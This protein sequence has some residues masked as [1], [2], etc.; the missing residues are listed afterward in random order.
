MKQEYKILIID[1]DLKPLK[2]HIRLLQR[3][4]Y[5]IETAES[6]ED[7]LSAAVEFNPHL[8]LLDILLPDIKGFEVCKKLKSIPD[9]K[10]PFIVMLSAGMTGPDN[11][12]KGFESGADDYLTKPITKEVL[13]ARINAIFRMIKAEIALAEEKEKLKL[14]KEEAESANRAKSMFLANMS[15]EIR[16]PMN[17]I[18]GMLNILLDSNLSPDQIDFIKSATQSAESLLTIINDILDYS[19]VEAG[20]LTLNSDCF[21]LKESIDQI[22]KTLIFSARDKGLTFN[23]QISK[24]VPQYLRGDSGRLRQVLVNLI[25]NAIKFT[26][27]GKVNLEI[28]LEN[29]AEKCANINF[30]VIDTGIGISDDQKSKLFKSFSQ[31]DS[32]ITRKYGGTGLGLAI[33][34]KLIE[35]MGGK[36]GVDSKLNEG[37]IF[38]FSIC[39]ERSNK[40]EFDSIKHKTL[41]DLSIIKN[42]LK[43]TKVLLAEDV[44]VNQKVALL[45]LNKFG[46]KTSIANNGKEAIQLLEKGN[47][48]IVLMDIQMPEMDG[49]EATTL[50]RLSNKFYKDIPIIALTAHAMKGDKDMFT[51]A[52]MDDY[53]SKPVKEEILYYTIEKYINRDISKHNKIS[54]TLPESSEGKE[55]I[56]TEDNN[57]SES[58]SEKVANYE[59]DNNKIIID[60]KELVSLYQDNNEFF[61]ILFQTFFEEIYEHLNLVK[62]SI[63][64]SDSKK[65]QKRSHTIKG[66]SLN[67]SAK[68]LNHIAIIIEQK[69]RNNDFSDIDFL[70]SQLEQA[71]QEIKEEAIRFDYLNKGGK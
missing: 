64:L 15:H 1:D 29:L 27:K 45:S 16:T 21:K 25:G 40:R 50:I 37:S 61:K 23:C 62:E 58:I 14:A 54:D 57:I 3:K 28:N 71:I 36:I 59:I 53:I 26:E 35:A 69:G 51:S 55:N 34:K 70:F 4:D 30:K 5:I 22:Q 12:V 17:G 7:G 33:C 56:P 8:I 31:T 11:L 52:G 18:V 42:K 48:D 6:G 43:D 13:L 24:D 63:Q 38:W 41:P 32:S 44:A 39:L 68:K 10:A 19:K 66:M 47:F 2:G 46:C 20:K 67:I 65:L 60:Q 49:V 9:Y